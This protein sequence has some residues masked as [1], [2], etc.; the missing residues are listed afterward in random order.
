MVKSL[1]RLLSSQVSNHNGEH[2]FC[3]RCL[4]PFWC[5]ESLSIHQEY[6]SEYKAVKIDPPQKGTMLKYEHY[7]RSEKVPFIVYAD[8]ESYIKPMHSCDP[9]PGSSYTKQYQKHEPS[10]FCNYIN[11]F[12]DEVYKPK[13]VS[14]TGEYA[15]QKFVDMLEKDIR[16][17]TSIKKKA[18]IFGEEEEQFTRQLNVGSVTKFFS[19]VIPRLET[20]AILLAGFEV[21]H[22]EYVILSIEYLTIRLWCFITSMG[23]ITTYS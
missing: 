18:I 20:I 21:Q 2:Y 4:N 7:H 1:S 5:Q 11:C 13:L 16:E 19:E 23:M 6:C 3:L 17:I 22:I 8:F 14:Y 9:N 10:S 15:A 12:D